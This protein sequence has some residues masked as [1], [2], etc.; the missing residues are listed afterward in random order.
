MP[1]REVLLT[2]IRA[3]G[4]IHLGNYLGA[5]LPA[6]KRQ[7]DFETYLFVADYH[8]LTSLPDAED[9][10]RNVRSIASSWLAAGLDPQQ[11]LIWKQSDVPAVLEL[12]YILNCAT[13][14][15]LLERAH[16]YKDAMA[17]S[18]NVKAGVFYYPV[19]MAADILLYRADKVPVG[20][21][22]AQHLEMTRDIATFFNERY[23]KILK[24]PEEIIQEDV[25]TV[26]GIDGR[27]M[28]KSYS[29]GIDILGDEKLLKKQIMGI[30]TDSR[31]LHESKVAEDC[32]VFQIYRLIAPPPQVAEMQ[33][34]LEA[35]G[36]GYGDAKKELLRCIL[37]NYDDM[38]KAYFQWMSPN[39]DL[40]EILTQGAKKAREKAED[41]M[42]E[43]RKQVGL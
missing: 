14:M 31:G 43:V 23:G 4:N 33:S 20:K 12:A 34:K 16:S 25:A 15:G 1:K 18:K 29:N 19:L 17:K 42:E 26:P 36:Y 13:G 11:T 24:L 6:I 38:R 40:D 22:Q 2:G 32:I 28:S 8:A 39:S 21:D 10:K 37:E 35:G 9:V 30:V 27:K 41:L 5:I 7:K 3:S